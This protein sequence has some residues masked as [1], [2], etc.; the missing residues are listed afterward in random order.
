MVLPKK[1]SLLLENQLALVNS[2]I[3]D[4][5]PTNRSCPLRNQKTRRQAIHFLSRETRE[6]SLIDRYQAI[7]DVAR[8]STGESLFY[9]GIRWNITPPLRKNIF[10]YARLVKE[11][12]ASLFFAAARFS[13]RTAA[14]SSLSRGNI[15]FSSLLVSIFF[16]WKIV[17]EKETSLLF[18]CVCV[19]VEKG[20]WVVK[21]S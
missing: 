21:S 3:T 8:S 2:S 10:G 1:I 15:L 12:T 4:V 19:C 6:N 18:R 16:L 9:E 14:F 5:Q 11:K 17:G 13:R 20:W 7:T